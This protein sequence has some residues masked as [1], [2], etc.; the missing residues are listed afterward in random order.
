M[1]WEGP[2]LFSPFLVGRFLQWHCPENLLNSCFRYFLRVYSFYFS[3]TNVR[4]VFH[5]PVSINK[6]WSFL[7]VAD[8]FFFGPFIFTL[9]FKSKRA[10]RFQLFLEQKHTV[11]PYFFFQYMQCEFVQMRQNWNKSFL[12][13]IL[14]YVF[15]Y[16]LR[17]LIFMRDLCGSFHPHCVLQTS[18][19][20][21]VR[22]PELEQRKE[23]GKSPWIER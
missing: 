22:S 3:H 2:P 16:G 23:A 17:F 21:L 5:K 6:F 8:S 7:G 19:I 14:D 13:L 12:F 1:L 4:C 9:F 15:V 11:L 10:Q 18:D 20:N